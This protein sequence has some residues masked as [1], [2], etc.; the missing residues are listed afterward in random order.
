MPF[1][2][3]TALNLHYYRILFQYSL[4]YYYTIKVVLRKKK[5]K[6]NFAHKLSNLGPHIFF[7][8]LGITMAISA[9]SS[10]YNGRTLEGLWESFSKRTVERSYS[11]YSYYFFCN[12]VGLA[13]S[14]IFLSQY[15]SMKHLF[16]FS[17]L[18]KRS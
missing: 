13:N 12:G 17:K 4:L 18:A 7:F 15:F 9:I 16:R 2:Y 1:H 6:K 11:I 14:I 10:I 3:R 8:N 5:T